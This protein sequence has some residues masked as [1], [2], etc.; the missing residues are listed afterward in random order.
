[1]MRS[2]TTA[3]P[4]LSG[5]RHDTDGGELAPGDVRRDRQKSSHSV[6]DRIRSRRPPAIVF[7]PRRCNGCGVCETVCAQRRP[8]D[9][10]IRVL[11]DDRGRAFV[12]FCQHCVSPVCVP[13]CPTGAMHRTA[14]GIVRIDERLCVHCGLCALACP[15]SAPQVNPETGRVAKCD[16]CDGAPLCVT[17]CP[18]GALTYTRG[19][20][21][22]WI[23]LLRWPVQL[24]SFLLLVVVLIGTF[25]GFEAGGVQLSCPVGVI[26]HLA[27]TRTLVL[28]TAASALALLGVTV[29]VGRAFCGW[30]CPFGFILDLVGLL[31]P[32]RFRLPKPLRSKT[33]KFGVLAAAVGGS[34]VLAHPAFCAVCPI[35]TLCRSHGVQGFFKGAELALIPAV[36]SLEIT[37]R[38]TWCRYFC[39]VG[40]LLAL[41]AKLGLIKIVIGAHRCKKFSCMRCAEICPMGIVDKASLQEGRSPELPSSECIFC[42]RCLDGCPYGAVKIRFRWQQAR[43]GRPLAAGPRL[44]PG[45]PPNEASTRDGL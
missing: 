23:R 28:A 39:P 11:K 2:D 4:A 10:S 17:H 37:G 14:E 5:S 41:C 9:S 40:A 27:A 18:E 24:I 25:C 44:L 42:L 6:L 22:G 43:P 34:A 31:V 35:G 1:M 12:V 19:K 13:A 20:R 15:E 38:R 30:I 26:Q 36:A 7:D 29:L 16:L 32:R 45:K 21:L 3:E 8:P 33:A